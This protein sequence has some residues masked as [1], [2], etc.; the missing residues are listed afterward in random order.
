MVMA[1]ASL[2]VGVLLG[3]SILSGSPTGAGIAA[4]SQGRMIADGSLAESLASVASG[5]QGGSLGI[6]LSMVDESGRYCRQFETP[7]AAGL[8]CLESE[9]WVIDTLSGTGG[10]PSVGG[11][12]VMADGSTDTAI[13]AALQRRGVQRVLDSREEAAAIASGW[14]ASAD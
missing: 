2:V 12:Y 13:S 9:A 6:R 4:D 11:A 14:Q 3:G 7:A 8:A 1:A 5:A 10:T